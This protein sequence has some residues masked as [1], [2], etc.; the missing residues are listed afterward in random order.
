MKDAPAIEVHLVESDE[1]PEGLGEMSLPPIAAA[2]SNAIYAGTGK[3]VRKLP[4]VLTEL[5]GS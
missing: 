1:K 3:R 2:L 5:P 4:I